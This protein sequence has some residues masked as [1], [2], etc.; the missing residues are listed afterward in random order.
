MGDLFGGPDIEIVET[1]SQEETNQEIEDRI[2]KEREAQAAFIRT[3]DEGGAAELRK[4]TTGLN[5]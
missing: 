3:L 4:P 1:P 5:F 2:R